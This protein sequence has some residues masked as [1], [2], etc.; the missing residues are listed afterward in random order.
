MVGNRWMEK[1]IFPNRGKNTIKGGETGI[2]RNVLHP[3]FRACLYA[4]ENI[5]A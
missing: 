4:K 5:I 3:G 1:D 2:D